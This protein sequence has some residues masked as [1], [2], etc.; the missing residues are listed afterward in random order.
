VG[1]QQPDPNHC[2]CCVNYSPIIVDLGVGG[3]RMS[4]AEN[5]VRFT[6]NDVGSILQ[7]GWPIGPLNAFLVLDRNGDGVVNN[8]S[9][10]FGNT[11][12][13]RDGSIASDGFAALAELDDDGNGRVDEADSAYSRLRL[14]TDLNLDAVSQEDELLSLESSGLISID[15]RPEQS[16]HRDQWGNRFTLRA[17]ARFT[18]APVQRFAYDVFPVTLKP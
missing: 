7:V 4:S 8:G 3:V 15:V 11:T 17:K 2:N 5:G 13:L 9:E 6:I 1:D 10:L 12:R 16:M 14:W 18:M